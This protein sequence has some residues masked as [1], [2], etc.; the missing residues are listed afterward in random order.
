[1][2]LENFGCVRES[3]GNAELH[4]NKKL[5]FVKLKKIFKSSLHVEKE[6]FLCR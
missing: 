6:K 5:S 4:M 1:M 3:G 2:P